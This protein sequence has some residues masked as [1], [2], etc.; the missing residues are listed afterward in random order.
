MHVARNT[1]HT[2]TPSRSRRGRTRNHH[3]SKFGMCVYVCLCVCVWVCVSNCVKCE[4][5]AVS[6]ENC[7]LIV[8]SC[9]VVGRCVGCFVTMHADYKQRAACSLTLSLSLY[10]FPEHKP[11][12][13]LSCSA[14]S[15][16]G[17]ASVA[18]TQ[19]R[20][21]SAIAHHTDREPLGDVSEHTTPT[22]AFQNNKK[23]N[24]TPRITYETYAKAK[25]E[26]EHT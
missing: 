13:F 7:S 22:S 6:V 26:S 10:H 14:R 2:C 24:N 20:G 3:R 25:T 19:R 17:S 12:H 8:R 5:R 15:S 23:K 16:S 21:V 4:R 11:L 9:A 1:N 18:F